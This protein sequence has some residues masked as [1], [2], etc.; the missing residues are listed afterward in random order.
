MGEIAEDCYD[1]AL[2]ELEMLDHDPDYYGYGGRTD[3][4]GYFP[5]YLTARRPA[6]K[7]TTAD[8]FDDLDDLS[9]LV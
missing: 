7:P 2:D 8:E 9:E 5:R 6:A 1:R 3:A 4:P